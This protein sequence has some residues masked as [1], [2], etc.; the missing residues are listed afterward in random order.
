MAI[1]I[2]GGTRFVGLA[3]AREALARGHDV[4]VFHRGSSP[5]PVDLTVEHI[6]GD[7]E[8]P[9]DLDALRGRVWDAVIDTSGYLPATVRE[10]TAALA[11]CGWYAFISTV[12]VY[13]DH[14]TPDADESYPLGRIDDAA[15]DAVTSATQINAD[16][17]GPLKARCE[18][19][20]LDAFADRST[21]VRPG[22]I[23]GPHD[24]TDR[25]TYW[26]RRIRRGGDVL[27]PDAL[28]QRWQVI[29]ARDLAALTLTLVE[30]AIAGVFNACGQPTPVSE[31]FAAAEDPA[32]PARYV[33]VDGDFMTKHDLHS[34]QHLPFF[35]PNDG[36]AGLHAVNC[37][38]ARAAGL[39]HRPIAETIADIAAWDAARGVDTPKMGLSAEREAELIAA[40]RG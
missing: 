18:R 22:L 26:V 13:A 25:F 34:W 29:D 5:G 10:A 30:L 11:G 8:K 28:A 1:L 17:Y 15:A 9:A 31:M 24:P 27:V 7:R 39:R 21:I 35:A 36:Y 20:V 32:R 19:I 3:I 23:V 40:W 37:D 38:R 4:T 12:S 16:N 2:I 14:A 6:H 33:T